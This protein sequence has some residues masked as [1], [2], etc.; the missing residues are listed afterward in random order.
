MATKKKEISKRSNLEIPLLE[1]Q[2]SLQ[3]MLAGIDQMKDTIKTVFGSASLIVSL[4]GALQLLSTTVATAW[5]LYYQIALIAVAVFYLALIVVCILGMMPMR[6]TAVLPYDWDTLSVTFQN[7]TDHEMT[8]MHLSAVLQSLEK[9]TPLV[10]RIYRLQV[11]ALVILPILVL[12][13]LFMAS[14]PRI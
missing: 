14:L 6:T 5:M 11:A 10:N 3:N 12:L 13:I 9:N 8:A 2:R 4:I 7:M 1:M